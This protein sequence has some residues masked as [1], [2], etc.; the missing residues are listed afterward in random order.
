MVIVVIG[1]LAAITV[2][3]YTGINNRAILASVQSD[4][5]MSATQNKIFQVEK[6]LYPES[7]TD[8]SAQPDSLTNK[9]LKLSSGNSIAA[10]SFDNNTPQL[11][12]L[13][14]KGPNKVKYYIIND[15]K[16]A[17]GNC[18]AKPV[19]AAVATSTSDSINLSWRA[20]TDATAYHIDIDTSPTFSTFRFLPGNILLSDTSAV[21]SGLLPNTTYY[22]RI[23][24]TVDGDTS[25]W[26]Y[27]NA[28]TSIVPP[29]NN[30]RTLFPA[31]YSA[32]VKWDP[33]VNQ[34][35]Y[36]IENSLYPNFSSIQSTTNC[37]VGITECYTGPLDSSTTYYFRIRT[38]SP[39]GNSAWSSTYATATTQAS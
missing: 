27:A 28:T 15:T 32:Y 23:N 22:F 5:T 1:I 30:F 10:Y 14:I 13:S 20:I 26:A 24:T 19:L 33:V 3:N 16:P 7:V 25:G 6:G 34:N 17:P 36:T 9:C 31:T 37:A 8:C 18:M 29:P 21:A 39:Y 35:G 2:V 38:N 12:C 4:L 11:F